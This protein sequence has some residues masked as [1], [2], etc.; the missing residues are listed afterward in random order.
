MAFPAC[1]KRAPGT[2]CAAIKG[3]NRIHAILGQTDKGS[4]SPD[5]CIATNPS[6]MC[7]AMSALGATVQVEGPHGKRSIPFGEFH[8][9]PGNTPHLDTN[10]KPDELIVAVTLPPRR[11]L[12][13]TP[14]T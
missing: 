4:A 13:A 14:T 10:L 3:Y 8:R 9:L 7:V 11:S 5:S 6:D 12:R 2:G 1:N